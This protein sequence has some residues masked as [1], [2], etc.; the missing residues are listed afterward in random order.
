MVGFERFVARAVRV[1]EAW[2]PAKHPN[3]P[4]GKYTKGGNAKPTAVRKVGVHGLKGY[5]GLVKKAKGKTIHAFLNANNAEHFGPEWEKAGVAPIHEPGFAHDHVPVSALY[6]SEVDSWDDP[7]SNEEWVKKLTARFRDGE[8]IK[9]VLVA[10]DGAGN[11]QVLDGHH[12]V[13]AAILAGRKDVPVVYSAES[14]ASAWK[15]ANKDSLSDEMRSKSPSKLASEYSKWRVDSAKSE[16]PKPDKAASGNPVADWAAKRFKSPAKAKEF[17]RWFGNSKVVDDRGAPLVVYHGTNRAFDKFVPSAMGEF[18]PAIY[19]TSDPDEA[20]MYANTPGGSAG[21]NIKPLFMKLT[22]PFVGSADEYYAKFGSDGS[23]DSDK[24][25]MKAAMKAG[26]DGVITRRKV[27]DWSSGKPVD[28]GKTTTHYIAFDPSRVKSS[29]GNRG[30]FDSSEMINEAWDHSKHPNDPDGKYTRGRNAKKAKAARLSA[31]TDLADKIKFVDQ[32]A[33]TNDPDEEEKIIQGVLA[34]LLEKWNYRQ[35]AKRY[36]PSGSAKTKALSKEAVGTLD[37]YLPSIETIIWSSE[38]PNA[39][40]LIDDVNRHIRALGLH[41]FSLPMAIEEIAQK[42]SKLGFDASEIDAMAAS[43]KEKESKVVDAYWNE[44]LNDEDARQEFFDEHYDEVEDEVRKKLKA[45]RVVAEPAADEWTMLA[46]TE[47]PSSV[48]PFETSGGFAFETRITQVGKNEHVVAFTD[49][50]GNYSITGDVGASGAMEVFRTVSAATLA[51]AKHHKPKRLTF[52]A[53][54]PNRAKLY[55]RLVATA[56]AAMPE[57]R[58]YAVSFRGQKDPSANVEFYLVHKD[59]VD[60]FKGYGGSVSFDD[61]S[62][63]YYAKQITEALRE[64]FCP[65]GKKGGRKNTCSSRRRRVGAADPLPKRKKRRGEY[66]SKH[67]DADMAELEKNGYRYS[68]KDFARRYVEIMRDRWSHPE[69]DPYVINRREEI[70]RIKAGENGDPDSDANRVHIANLELVLSKKLAH[71]KAELKASEVDPSIGYSFMD[72]LYKHV[73]AL[74]S[75]AQR[76]KEIDG[77]V[78]A[79]V[80]TQDFEDVLAASKNEAWR[81]RMVA[82]RKDAIEN[83]TLGVS[84]DV[85]SKIDRARLLEHVRGSQSGLLSEVQSLAFASGSNRHRAVAEAAVVTKAWR[86]Q[87]QI[88]AALSDEYEAV[89]NENPPD[90]AGVDDMVARAKSLKERIEDAA[91][92]ADA[93]HE[94]IQQ[95]RHVIMNA[96]ANV[97]EEA[98]VRDAV[99]AKIAEGAAKTGMKYSLSFAN[100]GKTEPVY[101][102]LDF[103][104]KVYHRRADEP[105]LPLSVRFAPGVRAFAEYNKPSVC[106]AEHE[107]PA[108][109]AH[110]FGHVLEHSNGTANLAKAFVLSQAEKPNKIRRASL[111]EVSMTYEKNEEFIPP[112]GGAFESLYAAKWYGNQ[113]SSEVISMGVQSLFEDPVQFALNYPDHF[114]F[115]TAFLRNELPSVDL[116]SGKVGE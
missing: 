100:S 21:P 108:V 40:S 6:G 101:K 111:Q 9:P 63:R 116:V 30:M 27:I 50:G 18:G 51:Y 5:A 1:R 64:A 33:E 42:L 67:Y 36:G 59:D 69:S 84:S 88:V 54:E 82:A 28:T 47:V 80:R 8:A 102:A 39:E 94:A 60:S 29:T 4:D 97:D 58:A 87:M 81:A 89:T 112:K 109:A 45:S 24:N 68:A 46:D 83:E 62:A 98:K 57:Y 55:E 78:L 79:S 61:P 113:E 38:V 7:A 31:I 110:E 99:Y 85:A 52:T 2:D 77:E 22:N 17:T 86:K 25:T 93:M 74:K 73:L 70:A 15:Q 71:F 44:Q 37:A 107:S 76:G 115:T 95:H 16:T 48:F 90:P 35:N 49:S 114:A 106:L 19:A 13:K 72:G 56:S 23:K 11:A 91:D 32:N 53:A 104:K 20:A 34:A 10:V 103:L 14:L 66:S 96:E 105:E 41:G 3:D 43:V 75:A 65:T 12:R 92:M 26:Y